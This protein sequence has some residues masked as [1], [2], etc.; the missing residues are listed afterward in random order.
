MTVFI[1][2]SKIKDFETYMKQPLDT[3]KLRSPKSFADEVVDLLCGEKSREGAELPFRSTHGNFRFRPSECTIWA[4][5]NGGGKSALLTMSALHWLQPGS[6]NREEKILLISPEMTPQQNL[7]RLVRQQ[8]NKTAVEQKEV[9]EALNFLDSKMWIYN[10]VGSVDKDIIIGLI[11]YAAR[12]LGVT[13][14]IFDNITILKFTGVDQNRDQKHF[15][16]DIV[17]VCRDEEIHIHVVAHSRKP[18]QGSRRMSKM[19]IRGASEQSDLVDN[20]ILIT[21][22]DKTEL[23]E[24]KDPLSEEYKAIKKMPDTYFDIAKQRH[25]DGWQGRVSLT[26]WPIGMRWTDNDRPPVAYPCVSD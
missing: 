6:S 13:Q 8:Q 18:E 3:G 2:V 7:G 19:D 15:M 26:Y 22:N 21:R 14:V 20:V 24:G 25:G 9:H 16:T 10:H 1:D 17:S 12:E 11:R 5:Q 4:G 23:L